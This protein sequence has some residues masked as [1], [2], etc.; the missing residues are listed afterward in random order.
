[1][2]IIASGDTG[3]KIIDVRGDNPVCVNFISHI[4]IETTSALTN[5]TFRY[6]QQ[7]TR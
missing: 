4:N 7:R 1:M 5:Y 2:E 6:R 3:R